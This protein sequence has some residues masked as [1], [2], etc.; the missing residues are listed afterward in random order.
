MKCRLANTH[1]TKAQIKGF[2]SHNPG[3][4][5]L[6]RG[7]MRAPEFQPLVL[8][9]VYP[10]K[11]VQVVRLAVGKMLAII[12]TGNHVADTLERGARVDQREVDVE[13]DCPEHGRRIGAGADERRPYGA[14]CVP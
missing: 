14:G 4:L 11:P 12:G 3:L 2:L 7:L 5:E 13:D 10:R 6:C 8:G 1:L 9:G